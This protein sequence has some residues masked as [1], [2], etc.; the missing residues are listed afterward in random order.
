MDYY[1]FMIKTNETIKLGTIKNLSNYQANC[2]TVAV[3]NSLYLFV[4]TGDFIHREK[5]ALH[6]YKMDLTTNKMSVAFTEKGGFPYSMTAVGNKLI[7]V[8]LGAGSSYKIEE[9]NTE[10]GKRRILKIYDFD[11]KAGTGEWILK[12]TSDDKSIS[13]LRLKIESSVKSR[14]YLDVYDHTMTFLRSVDISTIPSQATEPDGVDNQLRQPV[15]GFDFVNPYFYYQNFSITTFMGKVEKDSLHSIMDLK[16]TISFSRELV[17][18]KVSALFHEVSNRKDIDLYLLHY[19]DGTLKKAT[20]SIPDEKR[21][22]IASCLR[23]TKDNLLLIMFNKDPDTGE[24]LPARFYYL[25][26]SD[27]DFK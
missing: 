21:Y 13:L 22:T 1:R 4:T 8:E 27:L 23:D 5:R 12:I 10:T 19:T 20:F 14:L 2:D 16:P 18:S 6:L 24:T 25:N 7:M 17:K 15:T 26:V 9:Y 11:E 3:G